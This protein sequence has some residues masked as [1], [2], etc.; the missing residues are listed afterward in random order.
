M[1]HSH[2]GVKVHRST[3]CPPSAAAILLLVW[4]LLGLA[5]S[6]CA[7]PEPAPVRRDVIAADDNGVRPLHQL[8]LANVLEVSEPLFADRGFESR[9]LSLQECLYRALANNLDIRISAYEPAIKMADISEA[10]A[11]FDA[12]VFGSAQV[13]VTDRVNS[14]SVLENQLVQV[15]NELETIPAPAFPFVNTHDYQYAVGLR[16]RM[17]QGGIVELTQ[18][19][20]RFRNLRADELDLSFSPFYEYALQLQLTQPLLRDFGIDVNRATINVRRNTYRASQQQFALS[21][22]STVAEVEN[23]YWSLVLAR[24]RVKVLSALFGEADLSLRR[25]LARTD[26]DVSADVVYQNKELIKRTQAA[27]VAARNEVQSQQD[28]LLESLNDP[29]L[30][31]EEQIELLPVDLPSV[32]PYHMDRTEA[33]QTALQIRPEIISQRYQRDTAEIIVGVAEN[34]TLPRLDLLAQQEMTGAAESYDSAWD[35]QWRSDTI[36]YLVG[37]SFEWPIANRAAVAALKRARYQYQQQDSRLESVKQQV[38]ADV[39]I[40]LNTLENKHKETVHRTH[41]VEAGRNTLDSYLAL[42]RTDAK[43]SPAFLDRKL[44]SEERLANSLLAAVQAIYQYN[45]AIMNLHRAQGT[46]LHYNNI[47]LSE[48]LGD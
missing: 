23:N 31:L 16:K 46:L 25:M 13:T 22:I 8:T 44:N 14:D 47:K 20:R 42:E 2:R 39:T 33:L 48:R 21:V 5:G 41:A 40:S 26:L 6:A 27:L 10:E 45:I 9:P 17:P 37:V 1:S 4:V 15:G 7:T 28:R 34:Q 18:M 30:P 24:Q 38:L 11:A 19:L 36:N 43:I 32:E 35:Q 29:N 3:P 12:I